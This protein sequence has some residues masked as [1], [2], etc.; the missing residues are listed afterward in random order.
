MSKFLLAIFVKKYSTRSSNCR[1]MKNLI[2][3]KKNSP[4]VY[5]VRNSNLSDM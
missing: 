3:P 2:S 1:F 5:A 4:A